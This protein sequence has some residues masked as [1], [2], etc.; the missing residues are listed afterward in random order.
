MSHLPDD[1]LDRLLA[2][3]KTVE[4]PAGAAAELHASVHARLRRRE[5]T[6]HR[7]RL[8]VWFTIAAGLAV[9]ALAPL[10]WRHRTPHIAPPAV[11]RVAPPAPAIAGL[12]QSL[13]TV[14]INAKSAMKRA[15]FATKR[16][17]VE[18]VRQTRFIQF[19]TDDP[20][21]VIYWALEDRPLA[22][23]VHTDSTG[24]KL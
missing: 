23:Q 24:A 6:S 21:V 7:R 4:L 14:K 17:P 18:V 9:V 11:A 1:E 22:A 8:A 16:A 10:A 2:S 12:P 5:S 13:Q 20:N 3:L 19:A 15:K